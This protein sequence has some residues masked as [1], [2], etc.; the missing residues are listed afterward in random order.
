MKQSSLKPTPYKDI[1]Q[2]LSSFSKKVINIFGDNLMGIY[3]MGSLTYGSFEPKR[4]DLDLVVVLSKLASKKQLLFIKNLHFEI[5]KD[6]PRWVKRIE[7]SYVLFDMFN[8]V[9]PPKTPRPYFGEGTFY[10]KAQYGNEWLINNYLLYK[11]GIN[12]AGPDI[13]KIIKPINICDVQKANLKDLIQEWKPK[14]KDPKYLNNPHYQSYL[15]LNLCRILH[16]A[17]CNSLASKTISAAWVKKNFKKWVEL[18]KAAESWQY[19][20]K[21]DFKQETISFIKFVIN[22]LTK[23]H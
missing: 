18:I 21:M 1:N 3:L 23:K 10:P 4:S 7:C 19:G 9:N 11:H 22:E 17:K 5:E 16:T 6:N 2:I 15:I 20:D 12:L 14:I 13:K 8:N